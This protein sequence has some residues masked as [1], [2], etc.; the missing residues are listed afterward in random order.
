MVAQGCWNNRVKDAVFTWL[1]V[2]AVSG[3]FCFSSLETDYD[4]PLYMCDYVDMTVEPLVVC[5]SHKMNAM[6]CTLAIVKNCSLYPDER[7]HFCDSISSFPAH[8]NQSSVALSGRCHRSA[9]RARSDTR[10]FPSVGSKIWAK[11][12]MVNDK[13]KLFEGRAPPSLERAVSSFVILSILGFGVS[14]VLDFCH[15]GRPLLL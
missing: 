4:G 13:I 14:F 3:F 6:H 12:V 15:Y 5:S 11:P 7:Q 1:I 9:Q 10:S 8:I 2:T